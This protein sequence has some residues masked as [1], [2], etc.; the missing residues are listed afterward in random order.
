MIEIGHQISLFADDIHS[1]LAS[2]NE[3][4][5]MKS[6]DAFA[7]CLSELEESV[8]FK[9]HET[10]LDIWEGSSHPQPQ[11]HLCLFWCPTGDTKVRK[12]SNFRKILFFLNIKNKIQMKL[13]SYL[14]KSAQ[15]CDQEF[16]FH[17]CCWQRVGSR[18]THSAESRSE[19]ILELAVLHQLSTVAKSVNIDQ[20]CFFIG[21]YWHFWIETAFLH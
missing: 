2:L 4:G 8:R 15:S 21:W 18:Q 17:V 19:S 9:D 11:Y 7:E 12:C 3:Y 5:E 16:S 13:R 6:H 14:H 10:H 1:L 20:H